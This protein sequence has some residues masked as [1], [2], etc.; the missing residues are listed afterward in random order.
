MI[1][2]LLRGARSLTTAGGK[3]EYPFYPHHIIRN[4]MAVLSATAI[5]AALAGLY[6][7]PLER[8]A[9]PVDLSSLE[10]SGPPMWLLRPAWL[11][12]RAF[13]I[14]WLSATIL[15]VTLVLL[16]FIPVL[17]RSGEPRLRGRLLVAMPFLLW[18]AYILISTFLIPER[19]FL[20]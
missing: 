6:P 8:I 15:A 7:A 18:L 13:S 9:D 10:S 11:L 1:S 5:L 2:K 14:P 3:R 16:L 17:D 20:P 19:F 12:N 4:L